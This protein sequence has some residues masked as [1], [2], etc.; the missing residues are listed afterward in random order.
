MKKS[1]LILGILVMIV[2]GLNFSVIKL[3]VNEIDSLLLTAFR[4]SLTTL[5]AIFFVKKPK[6]MKM[7]YTTDYSVR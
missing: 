5:P 3:G 1:D 2:W 7:N 6:R 4:F